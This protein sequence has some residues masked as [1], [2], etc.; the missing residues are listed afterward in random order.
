MLYDLKARRTAIVVLV[1]LAVVR[2]AKFSSGTEKIGPAV[3][4]PE[5]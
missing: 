4:P 1:G 3:K 2:K 5:R